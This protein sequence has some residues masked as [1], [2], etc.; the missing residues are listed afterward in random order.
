MA[1][2]TGPKISRETD[3]GYARI[4]FQLATLLALL[5]PY[6][7]R[8]YKFKNTIWYKIYSIVILVTFS[9]AFVYSL[10]GKINEVYPTMKT[11]IMVVNVLA[12]V[13]YYVLN[14]T[15]VMSKTFFNFHNLNNM[16]KNLVF[17]DKKLYVYNLRL[18]TT[19]RLFL[20]EI[21]L[22][23]IMIFSLFAYDFFVWSCIISYTAHKYLLFEIL[24]KYHTHIL[25]CLMYNLILCIKNRYSTLNE[26]LSEVVLKRKIVRFTDNIRTHINSLNFKEVAMLL[27]KTNEMVDLFNDIYGWVMLFLNINIIAS[28][29]V[30]LD[31]IIEFSSSDDSFSDEYDLEFIVLML[32]WTLLALVSKKIY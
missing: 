29:L 15:S 14:I 10:K 28:F 9:A 8:A 17:I 26:L 27:T 25:V 3:I 2:P 30:A 12:S 19:N 31:F 5:P 4:L 20:I 16:V 18:K 23:H 6:D 7:F 13:S 1:S 22:Q 24:Q 21:T 11:T 32:L